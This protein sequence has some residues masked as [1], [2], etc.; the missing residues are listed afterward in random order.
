MTEQHSTFPIQVRASVTVQL[1]TRVSLQRN[2]HIE[3]AKFY[4]KE[5]S[6]GKCAVV[7]VLCGFQVLSVQKTNSHPC[8]TWTTGL[9][10]TS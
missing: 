1:F 5:G 4:M 6:R 9:N 2:V 3:D 10:N 8:Q 7:D